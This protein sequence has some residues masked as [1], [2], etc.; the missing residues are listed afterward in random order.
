MF[1]H[2]IQPVTLYEVRRPA[3]LYCYMAT[4]IKK[5]QKCNEFLKGIMIEYILVI[6]LIKY[7]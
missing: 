6:C 2:G 1:C 4:V 5:N 3:M 7:I